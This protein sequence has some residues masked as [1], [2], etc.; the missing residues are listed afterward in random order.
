MSISSLGNGRYVRLGRGALLASLGA[1]A[2]AYAII[3][4]AAG[5]QAHSYKLGDIEIGHIWAPPPEPSENGVAVYGA[6]FNTGDTPVE[7]KSVSSETFGEARFRKEENSETEWPEAITLVPGRP[8]GMASYREH[9]WLTD[10]HRALKDGDTFDLTMDFGDAGAITVD[11]VVE[12]TP[13]H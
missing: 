5:A 8:F 13:S 1:L 9:I 6:L 12:D 3:G 11:V 2:V 4:G 7:L 10:G